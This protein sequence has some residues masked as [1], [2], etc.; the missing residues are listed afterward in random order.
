MKLQLP[1]LFFI[2]ISSVVLAEQV[3]VEAGEFS[4][5]WWVEAGYTIH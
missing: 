1:C 3:L 2:F 4:T 5:R